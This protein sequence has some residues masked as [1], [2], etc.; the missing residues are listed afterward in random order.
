MRLVGYSSG[1]ATCSAN[2]H[3]RH[4][5]HALAASVQCV[6]V[7]YPTRPRGAYSR[8]RM[9]SSHLQMPSHMRVSCLSVAP[10]VVC[11]S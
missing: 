6:I 2:D 11:R 8:A 10:L 7:H 4:L 9:A 5:M 3:N 1:Y